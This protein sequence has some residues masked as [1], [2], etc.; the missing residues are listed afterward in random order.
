MSDAAI[1]PAAKTDVTTAETRVLHVVFRVDGADYALPADVVLQMESYTGATPV[2]GAKPFVAGIMQLRGR[3]VP[4]V[5]LRL[6][7][8]RP[9][10]PL[11]A[12]TRVVVGEAGGR[13]VALVAD[14]A[15]EVVRIA[16][17]E[18]AAPPQL[19]GDGT[20]SFVRAV[21]QHAGRTILILDFETLIG[22]EHG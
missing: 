3:V 22:D 9:A 8:G 1:V 11:S 18:L 10:A 12:D 16:P 20:G 2:P 4:V 19:V 14:S 5:D 21:A 17:S 15:R 13:A 6:R 7:F